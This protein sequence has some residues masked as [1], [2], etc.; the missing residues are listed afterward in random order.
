MKF[1]RKVD[2]AM[3][4]LSVL[5]ETY[6]SKAF[7]SLQEIAEREHL[8]YAFL[9]KLAAQLRKHGVLESKHGMA[10]GYRLGR[11]PATISVRDV[12]SIFEEPP[13]MQCMRSPRSD[14]FC[15]LVPTCPTRA[16]WF[17]LEK[18]VNKIFEEVSVAEL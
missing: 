6:V 5:R 7:I 16:K 8:P 11:D 10:G 18:R 1:S 3:I 15:P 4:L 14:K 17:L 9:E 12:L 13:M 2:Y